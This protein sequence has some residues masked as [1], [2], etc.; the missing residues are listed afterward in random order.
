MH[1]ADVSH[2]IK[3][4]TALDKEASRRATTVYLI[5]KR[6][7]MVPGTFSLDFC[8]LQLLTCGD[9]TQNCSAPTC[10]RCEVRWSVWHFL[11]FGN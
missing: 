4:G 7:D 3:P 11:A 10:A 5:D 6:L 8:N 9:F 1:I 2:F